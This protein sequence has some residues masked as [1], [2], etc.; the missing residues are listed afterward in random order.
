MRLLASA[1]P[2]WRILSR[3]LTLDVHAPRLACLNQLGVEKWRVKCT[4]NIFVNYPNFL[5]DWNGNV[6]VETPSLMIEIF[7]FNV[8]VN[9]HLVRNQ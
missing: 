5:I 6:N 8:T 4:N 3:Y 1:H 7:V 2:M 9:V